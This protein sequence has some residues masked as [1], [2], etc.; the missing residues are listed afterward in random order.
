MTA[1]TSI[2]KANI[3]VHLDFAQVRFVD[4]ATI[5]ILAMYVL[6]TPGQVLIMD[7][8]PRTWPA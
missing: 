4:L 6:R 5:N 3:D 7:E 8:L 1:L 2:A